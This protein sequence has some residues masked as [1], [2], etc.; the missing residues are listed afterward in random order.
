MA[1]SQ[2]YGTSPPTLLIVDMQ[3]GS[4]HSDGSFVKLH[5]PASRHMSIV[6]TINTLR[7]WSHARKI[8]VIYSRLEFNPEYTDSGL[9]MSSQHEL[10]ALHAF[11]RG[12]W[13]AN[14]VD[15]LEPDKSRWRSSSRRLATRL[16]RYGTRSFVGSE[17][18]RSVACDWRWEECVR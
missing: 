9:I 17:R 5:L 3:N 15:D 12:T 14:I 1:A 6:P 2:L 11:A 10:K 7:K 8:P 4:C 13:D 18:D 16:L